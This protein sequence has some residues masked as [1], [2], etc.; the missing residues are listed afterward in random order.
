MASPLEAD[1]FALLDK[2]DQRSARASL[3]F[4]L[5][6]GLTNALIA[7][8]FLCPIPQHP[9]QTLASLAARA[10]IY[11]ALAALAGT[12][13]A[14]LYWKRSYTRFRPELRF[15]FRLFALATAAGW[16]WTPAVVLLSRQDSPASAALSVLGAAIMGWSLRRAI[17]THFDRHDAPPQFG[18]AEI[19]SSYLQP[20]PHDAAGLVIALA[21][22]AAGYAWHDRSNLLA[23]ALLA[24]CAFLV[25]WRR[26]EP[27]IR[28]SDGDE[29]AAQRD[30]QV[31]RRL[32]AAAI[33]ALIVTLF[34][35]MLGIRPPRTMEAGSIGPTAAR[36]TPAKQA[37]AD[38]LSGY[39]SI[40]LWP[41]TQAKQV[42]APL[43]RTSILST[44]HA[45]PTIIRFDGS[46]WFFQPPEKRP[47][48]RAHV[49]Q[50]TPL[51][52]NIQ[53]NDAMPLLMEANQQLGTEMPLDGLRAVEVSIR[54]HDNHPGSVQLG[55]LLSDSSTHDKASVYLGE[56]PIVSTE[57]RGFTQ[58]SAAVT[59]VL[60]FPVPTTARLQH[61]DEITVI[62]LPDIEHRWINPKIAIDQFEL[63]PRW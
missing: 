47:G 19:F 53:S 30:R 22:Y 15:P 32:A 48:R 29:N 27:R 51:A 42:V 57:P 43:P 37:A 18:R 31:R 39:Q 26:S 41:P 56:Q 58:K 44:Q 36:A 24:P 14:W 2:P 38:S 28:N 20:M 23:C 9:G 54:N 52:A 10:L 33:P 63:L 55:V 46:Y 11:V 8:Y 62:F 45:Q 60:H 5:L 34:A 4:L 1:G 61:F 13:G 59:E 6:A 35:L 49:A 50:G 3:A 25:A 16:V 40:I 21:I 7:A 17:S 12:S